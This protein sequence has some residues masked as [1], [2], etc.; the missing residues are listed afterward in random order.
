MTDTPHART[1]AES[2]PVPA[3][4]WSPGRAVAALANRWPTWCG[5]A[6]A[7]LN[8]GDAQDGRALGFI[9]YLAALIYLATA[10]VDR[11]GVAWTLFWL[12]VVA[13]A[14]MRAFD[15]DPWPL[16]IASAV[17]VVV[18]GLA[19]GLPR[20]GGLTA[21]Q[22]PAM[23]LF[24]GAAVFALSLSPEAGGALVAAA[25][26]GHA[27]QDV[28]VLRAGKVVARSMAEFCAVL[29]FT[30]GAAILVLILVPFGG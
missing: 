16:L 14:L 12:S 10:V 27:V 25:L 3:R 30:L 22:L 5:L 7:A 18:L 11:P 8:L 17:T 26:I 1:A 2:P 24:G 20:R 6:A 23:L 29:D 19:G 9:V 13:V 4:R 15:L 21:A 28:A